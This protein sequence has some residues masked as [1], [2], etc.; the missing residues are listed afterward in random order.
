VSLRSRLAI[1]FG[2]LALGV[3][4]IV[5]AA[6]YQATRSEVSESTDRFLERR[7]IE[8][9]QG[10][11]EQPGNPRPRPDRNNDNNDDVAAADDA[12]AQLLRLPFDPDAVVQVTDEDGV[13]LSSS[14]A[15]LPITDAV[16]QLIDQRPRLDE[17]APNRYDDV[18]IDGTSYRMYTRALPG[19]GA[20]QVARSTTENDAVLRVLVSRIG[21][22]GLI[23]AVLAAFA[24]WWIARR[25]TRPLRRLAD[26]AATVADTRDFSVDVPVGRQDEIGKL[27]RSFREMLT[28]LETSRDQQHR[29][30]LDAGHELRT[31]LTSLR[32]NVEMLQRIDSR[33]EATLTPED[34]RELLQA[35]N[36]EVG[37]LSNL[38]TEL[39]ELATDSHDADAPMAPVDLADVVSRS[40]E[41]WQGRVDREIS[42]AAESA[43]VSGNEAMIER[44]V[45][46]LL[47]NADK[48]SPP[49]EPIDVVVRAGFVSVRDRGPGIP[50][51]D[52]ARVFDRFYRADATR[53]MPGSGLG[54]AIVA[55]IVERHGGETWVTESEH[56]G[57]DVGFRLP[58]I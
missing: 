21:I 12:G 53:T 3:S 8:V 33:P 14:S 44:A 4:A 17:S 58:T 52:R 9:T 32:A 41:R 29:L 16:E 49:G 36:A 7:A 22:I 23:A 54:L 38:F 48:F 5:G 30:V 31:P 50:V 57:A 34:R 2:L 43:M 42:L 26:V 37:E 20:I 40:V 19:G 35:I 24:G 6:S 46:N 15:E 47:G 45:T 56:G 27:A 11:R 18:E 25:T 1:L 10:I 13:V 39:M 28:A 55:Q 51:A